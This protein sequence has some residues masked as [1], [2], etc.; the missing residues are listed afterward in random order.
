MSR[1]CV[2]AASCIDLARNERFSASMFRSSIAIT[3]CRKARPWESLCR[4]SRRA[5]ATRA[6]WRARF[7]RAPARRFEFRRV[8]ACALRRCLGA[9]T[10]SPSPVATMLSR[11][12]SIPTS[13]RVSSSPGI[14]R[15]RTLNWSVT[16]HFPFARLTTACTGLAGSARCQRTLTR[17]GIPTSRSFPPRQTSPSPTRKSALWKRDIAR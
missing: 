8:L 11:P 2:H 6:W 16:Y 15:S 9:G 17:P 4:K 14:P 5:A 12:T 13:G 1:N 7:L 10:V 3:R